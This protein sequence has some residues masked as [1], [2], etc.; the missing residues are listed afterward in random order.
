MAGRNFFFLY[1]TFILYH[2]FFILS[3]A[4]FQRGLGPYLTCSRSGARQARPGKNFFHFREKIDS[5]FGPTR[6][7]FCF[8]W[9]RLTGGRLRTP[10][11]GPLSTK[12]G[13]IWDVFWP[14]RPK[15]LRKCYKFYEKMT[16]ML[17]KFH[18]FQTNL[19]IFK[20][21]LIKISGFCKKNA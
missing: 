4:G 20:Q 8:E 13:R 10:A 7:D 12:N 18:I 14:L 16:K 11:R 21:N 1:L 15:M 5:V 3:N 19:T 17:Q 9:S 2:I 6:P